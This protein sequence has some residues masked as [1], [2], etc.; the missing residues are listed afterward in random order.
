MKPVIVFDKVN[1]RVVSEDDSINVFYTV[2][3]ENPDNDCPDEV[4]EVVVQMYN[5][6]KELMEIDEYLL[7]A[8][9]TQD[10]REIMVEALYPLYY[11]LIYVML[12][13]MTFLDPVLD[14]EHKAIIH[15]IDEIKGFYHLVEAEQYGED[16]LHTKCESYLIPQAYN[17]VITI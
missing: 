10:A 4:V 14:G 12:G 5:E 6:G 9:C 13:H 2:D 8:D 17:G 11:P 3:T 16:S 7:D 1:S 15:R